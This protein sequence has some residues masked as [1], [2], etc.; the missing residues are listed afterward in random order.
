MKHK[1]KIIFLTS[2]IFLSFSNTIKADT[3][4]KH[5]TDYIN[6]YYPLAIQEMDRNKIPASITLAQGILESQ[7]GQGK[8]ALR[9]NNH[10]GIKCK[11]YWEGE[12]VYHDDDELQE[13]FRKYE[14]VEQSYED[15]SLFLVN[16]SRYASLF[17][18]KATDYKGWAHGLKKAGYATNPYYAIRLIHLIETYE[19]YKYDNPK[20]YNV[21]LVKFQ[22]ADK[23]DLSETTQPSAIKKEMPIT[24][25][26]YNEAYIPTSYENPQ[27]TISNQKSNLYRKTFKRNKCTYVIT[28]SNDTWSNLSEDTKISVNKLLLY[29]EITDP[30]VK[31]ES[32]SIIYITKKKKSTG[33]NKKKYIIKHDG[34]TLYEISQKYAIRTDYLCEKNSLMQYEKLIKGRIIELL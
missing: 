31:I 15:H 10:F 24:N 11:S 20:K 16:G 21:S 4:Q 5:I 8:L 7:W 27:L 25:K 12:K 9:S 6:I 3:K 19:L 32:G 23:K 30:S 13:C 14:T 29:N 28:K 26:T 34:E 17:N 2:L 22:E 18:L 1:I 33:L